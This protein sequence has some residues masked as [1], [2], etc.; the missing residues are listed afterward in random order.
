MNDVLVKRAGDLNIDPFYFWRGGAW[1]EEFC[2]DND[3]NLAT[4]CDVMTFN[5]SMGDNCPTRVWF[6]LASQCHGFACSN[7]P[8]SGTWWHRQVGLTRSQFRDGNVLT[9]SQMPI[10]NRNTQCNPNTQYGCGANETE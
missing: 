1:N 6:D 8:N 10:M 7:V 5:F 9:S 2:H 3:N 4:Q